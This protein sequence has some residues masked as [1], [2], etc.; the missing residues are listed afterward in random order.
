M[1]LGVS[2]GITSHIAFNNYCKKRMKLNKKT[3]EKTR[4]RGFLKIIL[5]IRNIVSCTFGILVIPI[6]ILNIFWG[7]DPGFGVFLVFLS[8]AFFPPT[9]AFLIKKFGF[10]IP[11]IVK[12][13]L[14]I[15]II[16]ASLGVG[17]LLDKIN[18]ML[19]DINT[20]F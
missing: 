5:N 15:F 13:T 20:G 18:L 10:R 9:N 19:V 14:G 7:N 11:S 17:E 4:G 8:L 3:E 2:F 6:G 12:I 16:W 1:L